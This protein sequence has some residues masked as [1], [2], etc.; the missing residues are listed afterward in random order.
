MGAVCTDTF[1]IGPVGIFSPTLDEVHL[2]H[3]YA[4]GNIWVYGRAIE[5]IGYITKAAFDQQS[6]RVP[7]DEIDSHNPCL[8]E[9]DY[10]VVSSDAL[11]P[12]E[13]LFSRARDWAGR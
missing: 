13:D 2:V 7:G 10:Q 9:M 6:E 12:L 5:G 11:T 4:W 8:G 1:P 3:P